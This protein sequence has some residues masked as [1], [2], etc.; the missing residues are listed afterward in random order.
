MQYSG[1]AGQSSLPGFENGS[2]PCEWQRT[3]VQSCL[4]DEAQQMAGYGRCWLAPERQGSLALSLVAAD[5]LGAAPGLHADAAPCLAHV[6]ADDAARLSGALHDWSAFGAALDCQFRLNHPQHGMRWLRMQSL[7][8]TSI[9][10]AM[11]TDV[12]DARHAALREKFNFALTQHL[13][14]SNTLDHA[15]GKILQLVCEDLGW[16][17]GAYWSCDPVDAGDAVLSCQH[18]WHRGDQRLAPFKNT[19]DVLQMAPGEGLVGRVWQSGQAMWVAGID[20]DPD[21]LRRASAI[22]SGLQSGYIFPVTYSSPEG[23]LH[24]PGV[25]EF[26]STLP[27]QREAQL[28]DL[29]ASIGA[30]IA[31]AVQRMAQQECMRRLALVDDMTGLENRIHFHGLL[32][33]ACRDHASF[34][35]LYIDLD[36]FKPVNDAFGHDAG[37]IVLIEFA[38]RL[39]ALALPGC[40]IGRIGGDEF[41]ILAAPELGS[42]QIDAMAAGVL[43]AANKPFFYMGFELSLSASVGISRFPE[44]GCCTAQL[45]HTSD[46]AMYQSKQGGRNLVSE[47]SGDGKEQQVK[48]VGQLALLSQLH[49]ALLD[50]AFFLEYQPIFDANGERVM[51]LEALIRW[52]KPDGE[53]VAPDRFIP[54]AEQS[55]LIVHLDRWV[56]EQVCRDLPLMQDAGMRDLQVHINMS[57]PEF[58]DSALA[59]GMMAILDAAGISPRQICIELTEGVVMDQVE[60]S[61]PIMQQLQHFGFD[62]SLDDFGMGY[63]SLSM[64]KKLPVSSIKIDR[65]FVAGLPHQR[66]ECAIVRAILELGRNMK[67]GVIAEGIENDGQLGFLRQFGCPRIQGYLLGRPMPLAA[68]IARHGQPR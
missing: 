33:A 51:A 4:P 28:P 47:F 16:E 48:M 59:Q 68:L 39:Q 36:H 17:W 9:A 26:F 37:N 25:L 63:S 52:R 22:D 41:A 43:R 44:H 7:R 6:A 2:D 13:V 32:D 64:L 11:V 45:L 15:L 67:I 1:A 20:H 54:I 56:L 31:Q 5:Y 46:S 61:I 8:T 30:L 66:D 34:A 19:S 53:I 38:R 62:I 23:V 29:A 50:H 24:S 58:L 12:T 10:C 27:R 14:S 42:D 35:V 21:F 55:R 57:A 65:L 49:H 40:A 3:I 60:K 18:A